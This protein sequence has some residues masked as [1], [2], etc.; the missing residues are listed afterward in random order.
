[1]IEVHSVRMTRVVLHP[2]SFILHPA[3]LA[4]GLLGA[5]CWVPIE[6]GQAMEADIVKTKAELAAQRKAADESDA[7]IRAEREKLRGDMDRLK[8]DQDAAIKRV[9]AKVREVGDALDN[10]NRS[11][12]KAGAD[13]GVEL[14]EAQG[15]ISRLRGQLE[16][17]QA[18][19]AGVE[20]AVTQLRADQESRLAA[21]TERTRIEDE[22]RRKADA[23]ARLEEE[24][25]KAAA[26]RPADKEEFYKL[27]KDR[28]DQGDTAQARQLFS[29]FLLKWKEDALAPNAQYWLGETFYAEKKYR[30]AIFEFQKVHDAWPKSDKAA[31]A[32]LKIA[33]AFEGLGL[34][35]D[36][37]VFYEDLARSYPKSPA[38]AKAKERLDAGAK[39]KTK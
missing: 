38:A 24:R 30:E 1:M 33:M 27:A 18:R 34:A 16:E 11:A 32:M 22:V 39:K 28:L 2:S 21:A 15:E 31:D 29:E 25:R 4:L 8:T 6:Q 20:Q 26:Q 5:G 23:A 17:A 3:L 12:R 37:S 13:L 35:D 19:L 14:E 7:R 10:L 36:A 9:D